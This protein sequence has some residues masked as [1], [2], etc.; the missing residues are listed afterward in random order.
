MNN[1][2]SYYVKYFNKDIERFKKVNKIFN[3]IL[4]FII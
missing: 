3:L 4:F 2:C 1:K